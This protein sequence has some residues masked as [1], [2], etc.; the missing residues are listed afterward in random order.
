MG[1]K[2]RLLQTAPAS[3]RW[4]ILA[5]GLSAALLLLGGVACKTDPKAASAAYTASGRRYL[6]QKKFPEASIQ[7]RNALQQDPSDWQARYQLARV[8]NHLH[9]WR[10][11]Y[12]DL[13]TVSEARPSFVPARLDLAE[14]YLAAGQIR[15]AQAEIDQSRKLDPGNLRVE[16]VQ[17]KLFLAGKEL[18]QATRQCETLRK[19]AP[20]DDQVY[21]L[22]GLSRIGLKQYPAAERDLRRALQL[23]PD[24]AENFRN[25]ANL[26]DVE[27]KTDAAESLLV[28]A[29]ATHSRSLEI[30]L[31][32]ADLYVRHGHPDRADARFAALL[33]RQLEFPHL[34]TTLG[35]FWMWRND[36]PRAIS[37]YQAA[38]KATP[39]AAI[40]KDLASAFLTLRRIPEAE[41]YTR[42]VLA[43]DPKDADGRALEGAIA[44]LKGDYRR[45][46]DILQAALKDNPDSLLASF[47]L[48][49]TWLEQGQLERARSAF[50]DCIRQNDKFVQAYVRLGQIALETGDWRLGAEYAKK[51][52]SINPGSLDGYL[53]LAQARMM[54]GDMASAGRIIAAGN[55]LQQPP[56]PFYQ[57]AVRYD[58]LKKH[59]AAADRDFGLASLAQNEAFPLLRWYALQLAQAGQT[60]RAI[61]RVREWM[62]S[63]PHD[64]S[65]AELLGRLYLSQGDLGQAETA[66]RQSLAGDAGRAS[67]HLLLGRILERR[68]DLSQAASEYATAI[69]DA[70]SQVSGYLLAGDLLMKQGR[71]QQAQPYFDAARLQAPGSDAVRLALVRCW[72]ARGTNLDQALGMAQ[73]LK[74][75][76]PQNP[77]VADAIG[78]IYHQ[79]GVNSLA[80]EELQSAARALPQDAFVQ[81]HLAMAMLAQGNRNPARQFLHRALQLGLPSPEQTAARQA[82]ASI[83]TQANR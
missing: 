76:F 22:C 53:L 70:P 33:S 3:G 56:A 47:Y 32:L 10:E 1:N 79:R 35:D 78:W 72:G 40:E 30:E 62:A 61:D 18:D 14:L 46:E 63:S 21:A 51:V 73:D 57:V 27:G 66:A 45:G 37:E 71:P 65:A 77:R 12:R 64:S 36:L 17:M 15:L 23:A 7:F 4:G 54:Q 13:K 75:R 25:L 34:R 59:F 19:L 31:A 26:L 68:G 50:S 83:Q 82:L 52:L 39:D 81:F 20:G 11:C 8:E 55:K 69:H 49:L 74:S 29:A 5:M 38:D 9:Q 43:R 58:L 48:G 6:Q 24:S 42:A 16:N 44:S 67:A 41:R 28:S 2:S 60:P 80:I